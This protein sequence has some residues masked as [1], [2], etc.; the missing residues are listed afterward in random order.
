M[1]SD[2]TGGRNLK[3]VKELVREMNSGK[4]LKENILVYSKILIETYQKAT[5]LSVAFNYD[6]L[7]EGILE[8]DRKNLEQIQESLKKVNQVI[9]EI[10]PKEKKSTEPKEIEQSITVLQEV[11]QD[12]TSKMQALTTFADKLQ[13]YEYVLNRMELKYQEKI[14]ISDETEFVKEV[15]NYIFSTKDN[16]VINENIKE[17]I[18][19]LPI[20]MARSYYFQ[21]I[22]NSL[23]VYIG[24]DKSS[25]E[26]FL[27]MLETSAMLYKAENAENFF[28]EIAAFVE[29]MDKVVFSEL[30]EKEYLQL[31]DELKEKAEKVLELSDIYMELQEIVNNLYGF[32]LTLKYQ[33]EIQG[34]E[35]NACVEIIKEVY[36]KFQ[37]ESWQD[38]SENLVEKLMITEGL[39][40]EVYERLIKLEAVLHKVRIDN[41]REV[42]LSKETEKF[43]VLNIIQKL[44]STS[45]FIELEEEK[46]EEIADEAYIE[47]KTKEVLEKLAKQFK[48]NQMCIN[49]AVIANTISKFPV[50]FSTAE[51]VKEYVENALYSCQDIA[52]KQ[53]CINII[54][55]IIEET[56]TFFNNWEEME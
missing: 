9:G 42:E 2:G 10:F 33:Q 13:V 6:T 56:N 44:L 20:R 34:E 12:N 26:S 14:V 28:P 43:Q 17:M 36:Q 16:M 1:D 50:F 45:R 54:H 3:Q 40:E 52:E 49:R 27:Y 4:N 19:Q 39:Q 29:K 46:I 8:E 37:D 24:G 38:I 51:E 22:T 55:N 25:V 41:Q 5:L 35:M 30:E 7:Y 11:R 53:A 48:K 47:E 32:V 23:S 21:L 18:G 31:T 15:V